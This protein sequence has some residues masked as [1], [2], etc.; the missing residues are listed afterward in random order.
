MVMEKIIKIK[1]ITCFFA[2][3]TEIYL[4]DWTGGVPNDGAE[5]NRLLTKPPRLKDDPQSSF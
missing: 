2:L 1:T 4:T 3:S 5:D